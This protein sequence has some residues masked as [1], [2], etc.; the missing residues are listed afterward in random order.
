LV[1]NSVLLIL[2]GWD[3]EE[4]SP[5]SYFPA[6]KGR[7][8]PKY[9]P[10][11]KAHSP[12][13]PCFQASSS[14]VV[15]SFKSQYS[16]PCSAT[17]AIPVSPEHNTPASNF[18]PDSEHNKSYDAVRVGSQKRK[19]GQ[20]SADSSASDLSVIFSPRKKAKTKTKIE[21]LADELEPYQHI[22]VNLKKDNEREHKKQIKQLIKN[23]KDKK[24]LQPSVV[25][26]LAGE[27]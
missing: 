26:V 27:V 4:N 2:S 22:L 15:H 6:Y 7:Y 23:L 25:D 16:L 20:M 1:S 11:N 17:S 19:A 24:F 18:Q 14:T 8:R 9:F 12:F 10:S 13:L 5:E 3:I 21:E